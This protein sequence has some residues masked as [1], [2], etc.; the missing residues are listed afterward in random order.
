MSDKKATSRGKFSMAFCKVSKNYC[1]KR[2]CEFCLKV[3][4]D[5]TILI[6]NNLKTFSLSFQLLD[7]T[8]VL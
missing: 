5:K 6:K 1:S 4:M 3:Y 8:K 7:K 2:L